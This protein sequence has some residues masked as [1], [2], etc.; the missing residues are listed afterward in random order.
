MSEVLSLYCI[1]KRY[2]DFVEAGNGSLFHL[3]FGFAGCLVVDNEGEY[4]LGHSASANSRMDTVDSFYRTQIYLEFL[5][6]ALA[7]HQKVL[8]I[9]A[10]FRRFD[11]MVN[12]LPR[13]RSKKPKAKE[14]VREELL[15]YQS[16]SSSTNSSLQETCSWSCVRSRCC[17]RWVW[18]RS[19]SKSSNNKERKNEEV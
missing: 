3:Q 5:V 4:P 13:M 15:V 14:I 19:H 9:R 1:P 17:A 16:Y 12:R 11:I 10:N 18:M 7:K 6:S 8:E 2:I